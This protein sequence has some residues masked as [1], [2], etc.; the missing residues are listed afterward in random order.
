MKFSTKLIYSNNLHVLSLKA[1]L[2]RS[3]TFCSLPLS[4]PQA[5]QRTPG[6]ATYE[7]Q[8]KE[9]DANKKKRQEDVRRP[10]TV[11]AKSRPF[12]KTGQP[13][14]DLR[15]YDLAVWSLLVIPGPDRRQAHQQGFRNLQ[16][17]YRVANGGSREGPSK[18]FS[19]PKPPVR[20][21]GA[22]P[23]FFRLQIHLLPPFWNN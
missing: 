18:I 3:L 21:L 10:S 13:H 22:H 16:I 23:E 15:T 19:H 11:V 1:S 12:N 5:E 14:R 7:V 8:R 6:V 17:Y 9:A 4:A 20:W 2:S